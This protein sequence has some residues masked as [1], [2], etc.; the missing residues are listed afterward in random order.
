[1]IL[2]RHPVYEY[3][4]YLRQTPGYTL[5]ARPPSTQMHIHGLREPAQRSFILIQLSAFHSSGALVVL[6]TR[7]DG[8]L[9]SMSVVVANDLG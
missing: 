6:R 4:A 5:T 3:V 9:S 7:Q 1:M 2:P 8:R